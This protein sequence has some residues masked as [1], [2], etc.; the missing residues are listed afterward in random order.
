LRL[1]CLQHASVSIA[2]DIRLAPEFR[3]KVKSPENER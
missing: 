2:V 1:K 3:I